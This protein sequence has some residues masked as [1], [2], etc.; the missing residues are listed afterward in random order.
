M[1]KP[2][3]STQSTGVPNHPDA[4]GGGRPDATARSKTP[5]G[6][7]KLKFAMRMQIYILL[8]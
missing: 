4:I 6:S 3:M 8:Q 7:W 1:V 2:V 5:A